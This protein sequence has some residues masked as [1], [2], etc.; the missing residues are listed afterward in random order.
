MDVSAI[1]HG[2]NPPYPPGNNSLHKKAG[3]ADATRVYRGLFMIMSVRL[4]QQ[5][6]AKKKFIGALADS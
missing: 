5:R 6:G 2:I 3:A 4:R 1:Q